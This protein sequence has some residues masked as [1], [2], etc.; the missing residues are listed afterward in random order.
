MATATLRVAADAKVRWVIGLK[1]GLG[2][3]YFENY[4]TTPAADYP[5]LPAD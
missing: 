4:H 1:A 5:P 2:F 3:D